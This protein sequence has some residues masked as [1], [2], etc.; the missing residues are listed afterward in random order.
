M[1]PVAPSR[2]LGSLLG[3]RGQRRWRAAGARRG[4]PA[5]AEGCGCRSG[6]VSSATHHNNSRTS[7]GRAREGRTSATVVSSACEEMHQWD[8]AAL[9]TRCARLRRV[10]VSGCIGFSRGPLEAVAGQ[11]RASGGIPGPGKARSR[12]SSREH[13]ASLH[14]V[15]THRERAV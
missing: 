2:A 15:T 10:V 13:S 8:T 9:T 6:S 3:S 12:R 7:W 5:R 1:R 11:S 14:R 4:R